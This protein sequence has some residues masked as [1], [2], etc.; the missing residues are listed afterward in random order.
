M[1]DQTYREIQFSAK[2]LVFLFMS[3]VV[4]AVVIFMLGVSVGRGVGVVPGELVD[5]GTPGDTLVATEPPPTEVKPGDLSYHG[6]LQGQPAAS[7]RSAAPPEPPPAGAAT[8]APLPAAPPP[9]EPD[10]PA[11][12][13]SQTPPP[14]SMTPPPPANTP[15]PQPPPQSPPPAA[16][17]PPATS[18]WMVQVG[19]FGSRANADR[20]VATLKGR[21]YSA[22]LAQVSS[23]TAPFAVR[24]GPFPDQAQA[25]NTVQ[26]LAKEPERYRSLVIR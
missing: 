24:V 21:G 13:R 20:L 1:T 6:D 12:T 16:T 14:S 7:G 25:Q 4:V 2:Q 9:V 22:F 18:G 17:A 8:P 19:A 5:A 23:S 26:R 10:P 3:A 11:P 15:P